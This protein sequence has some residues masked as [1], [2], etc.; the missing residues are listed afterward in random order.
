VSAVLLIMY[1]LYSIKRFTGIMLVVQVMFTVMLVQLDKLTVG[2]KRSKA[3]C[4]SE[5]LSVNM[6]DCDC[7]SLSTLTRVSLADL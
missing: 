2:Y 5:C 4:L 6:S 1:L 3:L 7:L